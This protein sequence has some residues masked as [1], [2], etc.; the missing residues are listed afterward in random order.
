[1]DAAQHQEHNV[2]TPQT[3]I[4]LLKVLGVMGIC[5]ALISSVL[6]LS[7]QWIIRVGKAEHAAKLLAHQQNAKK[8]DD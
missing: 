5:L 2:V 8:K 7:V 4:P 6:Y 1:M 3:D